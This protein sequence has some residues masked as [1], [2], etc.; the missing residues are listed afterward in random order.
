MKFR[1]IQF[2]SFSIIG[3]GGFFFVDAGVY[4][5]LYPFAGERAGRLFS[6]ASEFFTYILN[7]LITFKNSP[8]LFWSQFP[9]YFIS[10]RRCVLGGVT[11][12]HFLL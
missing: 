2:L 12:W 7:I 11:Y 8:H 4:Q 9:A 10:M 1:I 6:F 3:A 5:F